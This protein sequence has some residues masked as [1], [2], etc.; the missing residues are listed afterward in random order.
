M[1]IFKFSVDHEGNIKL[2][3]VT[4]C[5]GDQVVVDSLPEEA[6]HREKIWVTLRGKNSCDELFGVSD[7]HITLKR[8]YTIS[9]K[10]TP[11]DYSI[12]ANDPDIV[13]DPDNLGGTKGDLNVG[14]GPGDD[15]PGHK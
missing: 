10:A 12:I 6:A 3:G 1:A 8:H 9:S 4:A 14:S 2:V 5:S 7:G 11:G 15:G 13:V